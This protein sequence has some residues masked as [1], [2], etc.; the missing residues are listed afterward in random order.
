MRVVTSF[1]LFTAVAFA[2]CTEAATPE[3][4]EAAPTTPAPEAAMAPAAVPMEG[5]GFVTAVAPF[6]REPN[7]EK[8]VND[9][10][11]QKQ[12]NNWLATLHR[13]EPVTLLKQQGEWS[14]VR[15]SDESTGWIKTDR[16]IGATDVTLATLLEETKTFAR[17]D[18]SALNSGRTLPP[19]SLLF[20]T[21]TKEPFSEV[22]VGGESKLW[23]L[24]EKLATETTEV[25]ASRLVNKARWLDE[26]KDPGAKEFWELA[27]T[28]F[29]T[30]RLMQGLA[31]AQGLIL[32]P[33]GE[34]AP[35]PAP[36]TPN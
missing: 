20:V 13:G 1:L 4:G 7:E 16:V 31:I 12:V 24:T 26:Q 2:A 28:N 9:P 21:K 5:P 30:T 17:P 15:A 27:R 19:G 25:E 8:K 6:R 18:F 33:N 22:N 29:G 32:A 10:K 3:G 14:N 34:A 35:A 23:V 11:T 36:A